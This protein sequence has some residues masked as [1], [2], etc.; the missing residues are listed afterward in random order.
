MMYSGKG[1]RSY[2]I[3]VWWTAQYERIQ[4]PSKQMISIQLVK[5][6]SA[7]YET[8]IFTTMFKTAYH[9]G[10]YL[11]PLEPNLHP[12]IMLLRLILILLSHVRLGQCFPNLRHLHTPFRIST[13]SAVA[14]PIIS[15]SANLYVLE[16]HYEDANLLGCLYH[17][18]DELP[19]WWRQYAC[20]K[21]LV[22]FNEITCHY[23]PEGCH[24]QTFL[25]ENLK[26]HKHHN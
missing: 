22:Y 3:F 11:K 26:A 17:Q 23:I 6:F 13:L 7:S 12:H 21:S 25:H 4:N 1:C 19:W 9:N 2:K 15:E 18:G 8:H 24:L 14:L 16:P 10:R 20:L 5:K